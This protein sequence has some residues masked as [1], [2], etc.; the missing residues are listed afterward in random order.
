MHT[1]QIIL[2]QP[3]PRQ[4]RHRNRRHR[5]RYHGLR[6]DHKRAQGNPERLNPPTTP[7]TGPSRAK[8]QSSDARACAHACTTLP[9]APGGNR[10]EHVLTPLL[11]QWRHPSRLWLHDDTLLDCCQPSACLLH[12][13]ASCSTARQGRGGATLV[14]VV[15]SLS[16][17]AHSQRAQDA[18]PSP[19]QTPIG[20]ETRKQSAKGSSVIAFSGGSA[21]TSH[22]GPMRSY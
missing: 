11:N 4:R 10:V 17:P 5:L 21:A 15:F 3:R 9:I 12:A 1:I 2:W 18:D 7:P 6:D 16:I 22:R 14:S 20:A 19:I 8:V 13:S